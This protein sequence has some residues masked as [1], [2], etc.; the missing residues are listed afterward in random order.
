MRSDP[1]L[2]AYSDPEV[3]RHYDHSELQPAERYLFDRYVDASSRVLD[4]GVGAG[5]TT[6]HLA[7]RAARYVGLDYSQAMVDRAKARFA[8]RE[9]VHGDATDLSRFADGEFS[10]VVFSFNGLGCLPTD[11]LRARCLREI[12][13]VLEPGGAFLFSIHNATCMLFWPDYAG[14][15]PLKRAWRTAYAAMASTRVLRT[16]LPS[17]A[18]WKGVA[19]LPEVNAGGT[20]GSKTIVWNATPPVVRRELVEAGLTIVERVA[21]THPSS[22]PSVGVPWWYYAAIK[23]RVA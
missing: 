20:K 7:A 6:P 3:V 2:P 1:S 18:A 23:P 17:G 10:V 21:P 4:L 9:I 19:Y 22:P 12:H 5:R 11:E 14:A 16:R 8:E 13:R 15:G